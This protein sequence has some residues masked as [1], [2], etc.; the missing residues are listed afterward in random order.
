MT[1]GAD[2]RRRDIWETLCALMASSSCDFMRRWCLFFLSSSA[3]LSFDVEKSI[4]KAR[5]FI[6]LYESAGIDRSR[7]LIK[8][9]T[10]WEGVQAAK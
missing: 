3:R 6:Q 5:R 7:V 1:L 8:L 4:A 10:T 2:V 9:G